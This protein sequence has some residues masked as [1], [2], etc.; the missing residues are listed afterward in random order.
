VGDPAVVWPTSPFPSSF[1]FAATNC[2]VYKAST[3]W[4]N[5]LEYR[6]GIPLG[7]KLLQ[8]NFHELLS[9]EGEGRHHH[10]AA[11]YPCCDYR[12]RTY[13]FIPYDSLSMWAITI[14]SHLYLLRLTLSLLVSF[15]K[16]NFIVFPR[17]R[18]ISTAQNPRYYLE[19]WRDFEKYFFN[20]S[21]KIFYNL[22]DERPFWSEINPAKHNVKDLQCN[23][24]ICVVWNRQTNKTNSGWG[25]TEVIYDS[26]VSSHNLLGYDFIVVV[27]Y[28]TTSIHDVVTR[29]TTTWNFIAVRQ[30][31]SCPRTSLSTI[32][33]RR[34]GE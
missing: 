33:W 18:I 9:K 21:K 30:R 26:K 20:W 7:T 34:M 2:F 16:I 22:G 8:Y 1:P 32:P 25:E 14:H 27:Q 5:F 17:Y 23:T 6:V 31:S 15:Q 24:C 13:I 11:L 10:L 28:P 3:L 4:T 19:L 12:S 29:K